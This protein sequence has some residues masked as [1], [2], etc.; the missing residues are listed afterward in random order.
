MASVLFGF[1]LLPSCL[2]ETQIFYFVH[3]KSALFKSNLKSVFL[4]SF[5][6]F[7]DMTFVFLEI[8]ALY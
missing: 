1:S 7:S 8:F 4:N 2:S 5:K 6:N 3:T